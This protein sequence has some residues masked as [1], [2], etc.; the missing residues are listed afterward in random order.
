MRTLYP[1][2]EPHESGMLAVGDGQSVYWEVSGNPDGKPVVFL[3]GGPGGGTAPFHRRFFDPAAYRIVLFD[4]RGCGRS[5]PHLADGASLEHNTTGHLIAD[6]EALRE[7]L[8]V[9]RWQVF[10]GSWGS[11]LALAYAQRHPE[12]VTELVL[13]GIFL[14][15]RKEIDWYY[16]GAAGYVYPDEWEKFLAPVPEDERDQDLV[17]VYH[18]LLHSPDEDLARAAAIAWSTWEGA[19]S[20]LLPQPDR[21]AETAG[22]RFALA[23]ARIENHYFRHGGF[24]D[25][26]QLLRDIAAIRHIPAVIV[27]GR[28]DIVCPALSAWELHRAW[29][30]SV[31]HIVDDAGHAANEPGITHRLVEATDR[32]AKVGLSTVTTAADALIDALRD[33]IDRLSAA[34]PEVRADA[35]DSVHQMRVATRR[36]RSVLRSYGTLL[37]KKPAAAMNAELKW[38]AGLLGEARDAEVRADRFAALLAEHGEQAEPADLDAVTARLV[39]AERDRYRAAHDE[40]LAALDG[41]RYRKLHDELSRWRTAPPLRHSRAEAPAT[42]V[43]GE[44]LRRDLDRVASLVRAEPTVDPHERV[45][46]LHDIRKS[47]KRLRYSC[48]AAEQV[49]GDEAAERGRRAKKL[50]TVLGDHRDAVESH[51]AIVHRAAEAAAADEDA[52]L[53]DILAAAEDAA[54]GRELSRYPATAAALLG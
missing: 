35:E 14:L 34:E 53:Y 38:L 1:A 24:L 21:V 23:F 54:A 16:N 52:G 43:F 26:G 30:G 42:E 25:E 29:P 32:F 45:E 46:L 17:E 6:V 11:T 3:H 31:L 22:P 44:V 5:T 9:E 18:R 36:L 41:K 49:I 40:V 15:R 19:T 8:A 7:H 12:R 4:Q 20:S 50:Q 10:G 39:N 13:R 27:Q 47:A 2:I 48:E 33:D 37:V 28:H 51:S